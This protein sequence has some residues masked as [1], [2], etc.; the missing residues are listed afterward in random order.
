MLESAGPRTSVVKL[1]DKLV[2]LGSYFLSSTPYIFS[3]FCSISKYLRGMSTRDTS[4]ALARQ[5]IAMKQRV[6][7]LLYAIAFRLD[8]SFFGKHR[9]RY[10]YVYVGRSM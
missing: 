10:R 5:T 6:N 3:I 8:F 9:N 4:T 7:F 1:I 2:R